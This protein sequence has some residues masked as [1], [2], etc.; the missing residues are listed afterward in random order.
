MN[1]MGEIQASYSDMKQAHN[2]CIT[3]S[4]PLSKFQ[5]IQSHKIVAEGIRRHF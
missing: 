1:I 2:C 3:N 5:P 4:N